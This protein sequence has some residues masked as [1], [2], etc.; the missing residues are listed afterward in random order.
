MSLVPAGEWYDYEVTYLKMPEPP[1]QPPR[2]LPD[3]ARLELTESPDA[4]LFLSFYARVG[5]EYEWRDKLD[6]PRSEVEEYIAQ[7]GRPLYV[8]RLPD[9]R[10]GGFFLLDFT[11]MPVADLAYFGLLPEAVGGGYGRALL[12]QA[13]SLLWAQHGVTEV[14]VN[15]CTLDHP[16][17]LALYTSVGFRP[18]KKVWMSRVLT[19]P[20]SA[21]LQ[22]SS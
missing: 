9:G 10:E 3:G 17:A 4:D 20:R 22:K 12:E 11:E 2:A 13:V 7:P 6:V 16:R 15:T 21:P 14:T 18:G 8:L 19:R 5:A 1:V